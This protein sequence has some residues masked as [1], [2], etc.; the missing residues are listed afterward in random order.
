MKFYPTTFQRN[1]REFGKMLAAF[2]LGVVA[3]NAKQSQ[4]TGQCLVLILPR[5]ARRPDMSLQIG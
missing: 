5:T 2:S 4:G 3:G 1:S